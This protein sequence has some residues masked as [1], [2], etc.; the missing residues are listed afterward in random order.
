M[1]MVLRT[2]KADM[3]ASGKLALWEKHTNGADLNP[4]IVRYGK[5]S[6][7]T[8]A[9]GERA[10]HEWHT[11]LNPQNAPPIR[12]IYMIR[13]D[14][15]CDVYGAKNFKSRYDS[16]WK[17]ILVETGVH[18][19]GTKPEH[20]PDHIVPGVKEA[21]ELVLNLEMQNDEPA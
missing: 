2:S 14:V 19:K 13:D 20:E 1:S 9:W 11:E 4:A 15:N 6:E 7:T 12:T 3:I 18:E 5:P 8:F 21:V 16:E 17:T 10:L